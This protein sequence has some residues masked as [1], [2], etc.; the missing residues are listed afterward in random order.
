MT[1]ARILSS[2]FMVAML[3]LV[4]LWPHALHRLPWR[5]W[6]FDGDTTEA[7]IALATVVSI[8]VWL[9]LMVSKR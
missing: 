2:L 5:R 7:G 8:L 9:A 1:T 3:L 6:P 4:T